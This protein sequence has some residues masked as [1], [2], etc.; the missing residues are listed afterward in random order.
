L[1]TY[2]GGQPTGNKE[3]TFAALEKALKGKD[4]VALGPADA[5]DVNA[6]YVTKETADKYNLKTVSDLT[7]V[8]PQLVFGGPPECLERPLC[9]GDKS[10]QLYGL[11]FKEVKKLDAGG[12]ITTKALDDGDIQVAVL[13]TGSSVIGDNLVKLE[14]DKGLQ[15][16]DN[17]IVLVNTSKITGALKADLD[18]VTEK[19]TTAAYNKMALAVQNDKVDPSDAADT[20]LQ[21][22][23]LTK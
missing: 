20:F 9:L 11:D 15:P 17:T 10:Q 4:A 13:F 6:F 23:G 16:A 22:A 18:A 5:I 21:D 7:A 1:L 8:A 19:L 12:P 2:L 3:A 14:D